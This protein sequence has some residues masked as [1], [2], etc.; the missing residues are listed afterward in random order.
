[1]NENLVGSL[2][3]LKRQW[4]A[5]IVQHRH[6]ESV[7]RVHLELALRSNKFYSK[8]RMRLL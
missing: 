6:R 4:F 5:L 7:H 1:M 3:G 2:N 8:F